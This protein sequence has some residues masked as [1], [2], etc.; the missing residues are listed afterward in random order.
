MG[1][2]LLKFMEGFLMKR[3]IISLLLTIFLISGIATPTLAADNDIKVLLD[4]EE[5]DFDV[6]P[7]LIQNRT[8][9]PLR[10]IFEALGA[11]V[12][13]EDT[14]Q[15]VS[16]QRGTD[17]VTATIGQVNMQVNNEIKEMDIAPLIINGRTLVPARFVA[18]AFNCKVNWDGENRIVYISTIENNTSDVNSITLNYE[19]Y[20]L[21]PSQTLQLICTTE[22]FVSNPHITWESTSGISVDNGFVSVI[23]KG[24]GM[25]KVTAIADNGMT[26]VCWVMNEAEESAT[27][28]INN[29]YVYNKWT[30]ILSL[31]NAVPNVKL[32]QEYEISYP[33]FDIYCYDYS[34]LFHTLEIAEKVA[35]DYAYYLKEKGYS[36]I[37]EED[38]PMIAQSIGSDIIYELKDPTGKYIISIKGS[39]ASVG[40]T[41]YITSD[42]TVSIEPIVTS[43]NTISKSPIMIKDM[44]G[45]MD[46]VG[47]VQWSFDLKNNSDKVIKYVTISW[48]CYNRVMDVVEDTITKDKIFSLKITGPIQPGQTEYS[49][50]NAI[51]FYNTTY[52]N[53][54][55]L[56]KINVEYTD[57]TVDNLDVDYLTDYW[58]QDLS[59]TPFEMALKGYVMLVN[60]LEKSQ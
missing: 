8:M 47:G 15:T 42:V 59:I 31:E 1:Y 2:A 37:R 16:A 49:I 25:A 34:Y 58:Y 13:W 5:I 36:L 48:E 9:V 50:K 41:S 29:E 6:S 33:E 52:A 45:E 40:G 14:T 28:K 19:Y 39:P 26:A 53:Y 57:G 55:R 46:T 38:D 32:W 4:G 18:E 10:A 12:I 54:I 60:L 17:I 30:D 22:P 7:Q 20:Y 51:K 44:C 23:D 43:H 35:H 27:Q 21:K 11:T 56:N 24:Y 3:K